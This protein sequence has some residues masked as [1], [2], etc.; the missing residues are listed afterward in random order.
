MHRQD[1]FSQHCLDHMQ[2]IVV[3]RRPQVLLAYMLIASLALLGLSLPM[4]LLGMLL[5]P[6]ACLS[7]CNPP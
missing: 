7:L 2:F 5:V 1:K 3:T 6:S 4:L